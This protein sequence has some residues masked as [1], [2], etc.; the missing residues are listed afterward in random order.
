MYHRLATN[1]LTPKGLCYLFEYLKEDKKITVLNVAY[2]RCDDYCL[3][4]LGEMLSTNDTLVDVCVG[5]Q[6]YESSL[7]TSM[8]NSM[9]FSKVSN[10]GIKLLLSSLKS[11]KTLDRLSFC[12]N[13]INHEC[14]PY[15]CEIMDKTKIT[16]ISFTIQELNKDERLVKRVIRN[17]IE[18]NPILLSLQDL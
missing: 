6:V 5:G 18:R 12:S 3:E 14:I 8:Y 13:R 2:N 17:S 16:K 1:L 7:V 4:K 11:N 9:L 15:A 10:N